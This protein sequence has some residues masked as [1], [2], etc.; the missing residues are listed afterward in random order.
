MLDFTL[1]AIIWDDI[2]M[3]KWVLVTHR[4]NSNLFMEVLEI[5]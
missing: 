5:H 1:L 3:H 4:L 2:E